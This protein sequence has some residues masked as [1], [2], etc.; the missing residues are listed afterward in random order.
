LA[1]KEVKES[2][3]VETKY[4]RSHPAGATAEERLRNRY[5]NSGSGS[6]TDH[7][8]WKQGTSPVR[9]VTNI[10]E[11]A[12]M[13]TPGRYTTLLNAGLSRDHFAYNRE[14]RGGRR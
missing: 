9:H 5:R 14:G 11:F 2:E 6:Y 1:S 13:P 12:H 7:E 4:D 10:S 3:M 8:P